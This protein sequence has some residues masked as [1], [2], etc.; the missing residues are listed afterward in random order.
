[1]TSEKKSNSGILISL[2]F[3]LLVSITINVAQFFLFPKMIKNQLLEHEYSKV[4]WKEAYDTITELQVLY[5]NYP[6][7]PQ[8]LKAQKEII[9]Q[10]KAW[11]IDGST[12][13]DTATP[14]EWNTLTKEQMDDILSTAIVEGNLDTAEV[15]MVEY[16]DMECPFCVR[17]QND[18]QISKKLVEE[19][20]DKVAIVFKNHRWVN[21]RWTEVK[22]L[23]LLCA[24]RVGGKEAYSAFYRAMFDYTAKN[25]DY[26]PV[27]KLGELASSIGL[28]VDAWQSC[29]DNKETL[30]QF[31]KETNE[32]ISFG[33]RWTPGSVLF[34]LKTGEYVTVEGAYPYTR[35]QSSVNTLLGK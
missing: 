12:D 14:K 8:N 17:Q 20:G 30:D 11:W 6:D 2:V 4:G 28:N 15:V 22:A 16:S 21:H 9:K 5:N 33:L 34:N 1:M 10:L 31:N 35:F 26:Y 27:D 18:N 7:N 25:S 19:Y 23:G 13:H 24:N 3:L 32:A 29:V